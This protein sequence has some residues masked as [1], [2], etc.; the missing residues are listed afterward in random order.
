M[1][2]YPFLL[3]NHAHSP[4]VLQEG[5]P[6]KSAEGFSFEKIS[7]HLDLEFVFESALLLCCSTSRRLK[8]TTEYLGIHIQRSAQPTCPTEASSRILLARLPQPIHGTKIPLLSWACMAS[9][10]QVQNCTSEVSSKT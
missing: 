3:G 7:C 4:H 10:V 1:A 8:V 2:P 9:K 5:I 6:P